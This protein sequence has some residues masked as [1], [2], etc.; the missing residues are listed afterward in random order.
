MY[1]LSSSFLFRRGSVTLSFPS[2]HCL[3]NVQAGDRFSVCTGINCRSTFLSH[4]Q[5]FVSAKPARSEPLEILMSFPCLKA[6]AA[7]RLASCLHPANKT[8]LTDVFENLID[9]AGCKDSKWWPLHPSSTPFAHT[10][11]GDVQTQ[12]HQVCRAVDILTDVTVSAMSDLDTRSASRLHRAYVLLHVAEDAEKEQLKKH[13]AALNRRTEALELLA[14]RYAKSY[15]LARQILQGERARRQNLKL[16][17][18]QCLDDLDAGRAGDKKLRSCMTGETHALSV[19][20][21][22]NFL[23]YQGRPQECPKVDEMV[24][25]GLHFDQVQTEGEDGR[26]RVDLT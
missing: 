19:A 20:I 24:S 7:A 18:Q 12:V 13:F 17:L 5:D 25:K 8:P 9:E 23:N 2:K 11:R 26:S 15:E 10:C 1:E 6:Q 21:L 22:C 3:S 4:L 16:G 14:R